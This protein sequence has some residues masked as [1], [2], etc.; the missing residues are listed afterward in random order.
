MSGVQHADC[1]TFCTPVF[2]FTKD[3]TRDRKRKKKREREKKREE[4]KK[5]EK[6]AFVE[7]VTFFSWLQDQLWK[8]LL[9]L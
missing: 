6:V 9:Q 4:A 7:G 8:S 5:K 3:A 1:V 2:C